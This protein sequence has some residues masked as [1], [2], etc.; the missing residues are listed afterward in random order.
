MGIAKFFINNVIGQNRFSHWMGAFSDASIPNWILK[1]VIRSYVRYYK[2]DLNDYDINLNEIKKFNAFFTRQ[3]KE[4]K[5]H[6]G[7]GVVSPVDGKLINYGLL[8]SSQLL[9]C[10]GQWYPQTGITS[11]EAFDHGSFATIYLSPADYHRVH[12]PFDMKIQEIVYIP[13]TL[14]PV[15]KKS[16]LK[17]DRLFCRNER[18]VLS[19]TCEY[20][21]FHF[22]FV[23]AMIVGRTVLSFD[24][25]WRSNIKK[26]KQRQEKVDFQIAKGEE[27]GY[28]ELGSTVIF[29]I[30]SEVLNEIKITENTQVKMGESMFIESD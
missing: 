19:G 30:D 11:L 3:F 17:H 7:K 22:V 21:H 14:F 10:K 5:R 28:F 2:I 23:G 4:G 9:Q 20:G 18:I 12:A 6:I 13:G 26:G 24:S 1:N 27:L 15:N 16:V 29:M 25:S 8:Q